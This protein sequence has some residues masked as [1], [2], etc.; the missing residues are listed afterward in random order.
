MSSLAPLPPATP[1]AQKPTRIIKPRP[2][3]RPR[4]YL[5][6]RPDSAKLG[7]GPTPPLAPEGSVAEPT[8]DG[9]PRPAEPPCS[10][11]QQLHDLHNS[12][13]V[14]KIV[15][16]FDHAGPEK[17]DASKPIRPGL[18]CA[19]GPVPVVENGGEELVQEKEEPGQLGKRAGL[20]GTSKAN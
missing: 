1:P 6:P 7:R 12:G 18:T 8:S 10:D 17:G 19:Q 3:T 13:N 5:P 16:R 11:H 20:Q 4:P 15:V 9:C 2:P 14:R